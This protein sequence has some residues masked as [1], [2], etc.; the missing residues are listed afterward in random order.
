MQKIEIKFYQI[1]ILYSFQTPLP[2]F[3]CGMRVVSLCFRL[4]LGHIYGS[5]HFRT[6]WR[7]YLDV[8][9]PRVGSCGRDICSMIR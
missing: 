1:F 5:Q 3:C 9:G 7:K 6:H 2:C 8:P 4:N